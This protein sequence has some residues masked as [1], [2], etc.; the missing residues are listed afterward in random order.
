MHPEDAY[1]A[2]RDTALAGRSLEGFPLQGE[3]FHA[4]MRGFR[5][6]QS[7]DPACVRC[8][9]TGLVAAGSSGESALRPLSVCTC[10]ALPLEHGD[11]HLSPPAR[12]RKFVNALERYIA[13]VENDANTRNLAVARQ[14]LALMRHGATRARLD[15]L[16]VAVDALPCS[17]SITVDLQLGCRHWIRS[18]LARL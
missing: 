4:W 11:A 17:G 18:V 3:A 8:G 12:A 7:F 9:G 2:G 15:E 16:L 14:W 6:H 13:T 10:N 1:A 5:D